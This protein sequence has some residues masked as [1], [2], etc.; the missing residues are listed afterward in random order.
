MHKFR[1]CKVENAK[2]TLQ[3]ETE[4]N[5]YQYKICLNY[6]NKICIKKYLIY[7][8]LALNNFM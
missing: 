1:K 5:I 2:S 7:L 4:Y 6:V 3:S 8:I